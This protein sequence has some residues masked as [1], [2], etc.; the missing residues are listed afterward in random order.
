LSASLFDEKA[1]GYDCEFT[2]TLIGSLMRQA[3]W[4]RCAARLSP[5]AR[6]L[7]MNC[8]T[9]EDA[10][11]LV[12]RGIHVLATDISLPMLHIAERKVSQSPNRHLAQFRQLAWED[13]TTLHVGPFDGVLSNFG[14]LNCV[15]DLNEAAQALAGKLIIGGIAILCIMGR[16]VPWEW[17]WFLTQGRPAAAFRRL[18][19]GGAMWSGT[20]I[21]YPSIKQTRASFARHFRVLRVA[22][23][24]ALLP[25]P[26]TKTIFS[27]YGR[28][29]AALASL[30]RRIE[31]VW[32]VP[33][34]ADHY[35]IELERI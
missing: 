34:L 20:T 23:I 25:P 26:Y 17:L 22:G 1:E 31:T 5:G 4:S 8:G 16:S 24:A 35:L 10:L 15:N 30:E 19:S 7:E 21:R 18:R 11:W 13:L 32:P 3:V 14:G 27:R 12:N 29:I 2:Q 28:L 6:I 33:V 9:G